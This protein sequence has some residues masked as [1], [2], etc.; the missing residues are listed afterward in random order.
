MRC[1]RRC[2]GRFRGSDCRCRALRHFVWR[3]LGPFHRNRVRFHRNRVRFH[4][5]LR[6]GCHAWL[7]RHRL[8]RLRNY[9]AAMTI[10]AIATAA[11]TSP[12]SFARFARRRSGRAS[13]ARFARRRGGRA[14][15]RGSLL[16]RFSRGDFFAHLTRL[17]G[18]TRPILLLCFSALSFRT[19]LVSVALPAAATTVALAP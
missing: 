3:N 14:F 2:M 5:R 6:R 15:F 16:L 12:A 11:T 8:V 18:R 1:G 9:F 7:A 17:A 13:F 4:A 19:P 10:V